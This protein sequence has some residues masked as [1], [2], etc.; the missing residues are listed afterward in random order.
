[1]DSNTRK[2]VAGGANLAAGWYVAKYFKMP[3][4][5]GIAIELWAMAAAERR[6]R[7]GLVGPLLLPGDTLVN[8]LEAVE[9]PIA[10]AP[11]RTIDTPAGPVVI[12]NKPTSSTDGPPA[13]H[14][15]SDMMG[16]K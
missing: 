10:V 3:G 9:D 5:V 4:V 7:G 11:A 12:D 16:P 2:M 1:M 6:G 14:G 13:P 15:P 8:L